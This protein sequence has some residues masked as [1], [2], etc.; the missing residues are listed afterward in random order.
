VL[1]TV[2]PVFAR[3]ARVRGCAEAE[4]EQAADQAGAAEEGPLHS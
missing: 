1:L 4:D 2:L 3:C